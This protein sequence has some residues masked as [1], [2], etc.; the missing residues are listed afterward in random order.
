LAY[1]PYVYGRRYRDR[2]E[3]LRRLADNAAID[4]AR[5]T[6]LQLAAQCEALA[7]R[8]DADATAADAGRS[9]AG[10][11]AGGQTYALALGRFLSRR[12]RF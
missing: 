1:H 10:A 2:A 3:E 7:D 8:A 6:Y 4:T 12:R 5:T 9:Y 11:A